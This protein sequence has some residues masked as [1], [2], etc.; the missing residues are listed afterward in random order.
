LRK[1]IS[2]K[3]SPLYILNDPST[4]P[5]V[6]T[7][8][9]G[10]LDFT[11]RWLIE[12]NLGLWGLNKLGADFRMF[13]F[14]FMQGRMY[15]NNVVA[16]FDNISPICTFCEIKSRADL[17]V[18]GITVDMPEYPYY[19]NLQPVE[20][21]DHL[22]WECPTSNLV[23]QQCYRWIRGFDWYNGI[24][25]MD[26][27]EFLIGIDNVKKSIVKVD[28]IWKH[29]VRYFIYKCKIAKRIP[30]FPSLKHELEGFF[31]NPG[32]YRLRQEM[33]GVNELY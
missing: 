30:H 26:K 31:Y 8:W 14:N 7:L 20:S 18:R 13:I 24:E 9:G 21:V 32:M 11:N 29:F 27:F 17:Y 22:F 16:R 23:I 33:Q 1:I 10:A 25:E 4:V 12:L 28:L 5:S 15:L 2:G 3:K 6:Q 19:M